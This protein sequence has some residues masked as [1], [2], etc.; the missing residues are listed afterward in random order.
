MGPR[1]EAF[2]REFAAHLGCEHMLALSSE[3]P[4]AGAPLNEIGREMGSDEAAGAR[5]EYRT[6]GYG[7]RAQDGVAVF[8][9]PWS[10]AG[11]I[12]PGRKRT[13]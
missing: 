4:H 9:C 5:D 12:R 2:E 3:G 8:S 10:A 11:S 7:V 1:T 6:P 13:L